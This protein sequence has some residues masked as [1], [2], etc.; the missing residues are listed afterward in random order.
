[1]KNEN[2]DSVARIENRLRQLYTNLNQLTG[3]TPETLR[4]SYQNFSQV[5]AGE[6]A[7]SMAYYAFF[8]L[9]PLLLLL[10]SILGFFLSTGNNRVDI[11]NYVTRFVPIQ[12]H[13]IQ[14]TLLAILKARNAVGVIGLVG[15][16]WSASGAFSA[17]AININRAWSVSD[18]RSFFADRLLALGMI[19]VISLV[20]L[21][22]MIASSLLSLLPSFNI[23]LL[24][25]FSIYYTFLWKA[26]IRLLPWAIACLVFYLL[27]KLLPTT[28]VEPRAALWG[29]LVAGIAWEVLTSLFTWYLGS[30]LANY[31]AVYGSLGAIVGL[32]TWIYLSAWITLFGAHVSAAVSRHAEMQVGANQSRLESIHRSE[33]AA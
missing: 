24:G 5:R 25:S 1:M 7:A 8:S 17:L 26:F 14:Q 18:A 2:P 20:L 22:I 9:F 30:G 27:Y 4:R 29:A 10:S 23:P 33:H 31:Q 19:A 16:L 28:Y 6:A 13:F 11:V 3:G 12:E 21:I 32:L 15:L